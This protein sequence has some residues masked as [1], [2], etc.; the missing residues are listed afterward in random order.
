MVSDVYTLTRFQ[1]DFRAMPEETERTARYDRLDA[2]S[3]LR[4][5]LL[6]EE[7]ICML[8]QLL[9]YGKG[10]FWIEA[11]N[12]CY[13][14]RLQVTPESSDFDADKVISVSGSG[15]N[16]NRSAGKTRLTIYG[17]SHRYSA[18]RHG[19]T[20]RDR[21]V[22]VKCDLI[23]CETLVSDAT[24]NKDPCLIFM[25][26]APFTARDGSGKNCRCIQRNLL[27]GIR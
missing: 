18:I 9:I 11:E 1:T 13:S 3:A 16:V 19:P 20:L 4:L 23:R 17:D 22:P 7:M 21:N 14:L 2:R 12:K 10:R 26:H 24:Q 25:K 5:R 15:R 6:A 27:N 8:P